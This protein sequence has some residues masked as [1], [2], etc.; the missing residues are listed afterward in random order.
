MRGLR[1]TRPVCHRG[2]VARQILHRGKSTGSP[3]TGSARHARRDVFVSYAREDVE[4]V[5]RLH[6]RLQE[7]GKT[8]YVDFSDIP[9]WSDD[10]QRELYA[11]I[12]ASDTF[13]LVIS[14]DSIP[15]PNVARELDRAVAQHKRLKPLLLRDVDADRVPPEVARP[16]WIDFRDA[17]GFD[18]RFADL[19]T[20]LGT[21]V[22]WVR[23]HTRFLLAANDWEGRGEDRSLLLGRSDLRD[24]DG[25]LARQ[26]GKDPAPS[27]LQIRFILASRRA[28]ARRQRLLLGSVVSALA[29]TAGLAIFAFVQRGQAIDQRDQARSRELAAL[30]VAQ[31]GS[32]PREGLRLALQ[33]A[34]AANT[35]QAEGALQ[36]AAAQPEVRAVLGTEAS[37]SSPITDSAVTPDGRYAVTVHQDRLGR[38]WDLRSGRL[39]ATLR[40]HTAPIT[41][42]DISSDG[43]LAVT[44][45]DRRSSKLSDGAA[46][47]WALPSGRL[48]RRLRSDANGII[49]AVFSPDGKSV[50]TIGDFDALDPVVIW[51]V[52]SGKRLHAFGEPGENHSAA[53]SPDG[54]RVATLGVTPGAQVAVWDARRGALVRKFRL[55]QNQF[56]NDLAFSPD[57]RRLAVAGDGVGFIAKLSNG[58]IQ[59]LPGRHDLFDALTAVR[60]CPDGTCVVTTSSDDTAR[61]WS[62]SG[63]QLTL[64]GH[65][66]DVTGSSSS[67]DGRLVLTESEDGT[68]R[69]WSRNS[70]AQLAVL[71]GHK[72]PVVGADF[73]GRSGE[74]LTTSGDGTGFVW[75]PGV[76]V[77]YPRGDLVADASFGQDGD[78][79]ATATLEG[80]AAIWSSAGKL[81]HRLRSGN[82]APYDRIAFSPDGTRLL[83]GQDTVS[84]W[85]STGKHLRSFD[86][87]L[88]YPIFSPD[89]KLLA[90]GGT[91]VVALF[92]ASDGRRIARLAVGSPQDRKTAVFLPSFSGDSRLVA[93]P[94]ALTG[95]HLWD[96]RRGGRSIDLRT[97]ERID[98]VAF[99][100]DGKQL[101]TSGD[102]VKVARVWDVGARTNVV[103][104]RYP[105][106]V[107][108]LAYS[109]D[110]NL[111]SAVSSGERAVRIYDAHT[112]QRIA[113][114]RD[115][116][117]TLDASF[118][119]DSRLLLTVSNSATAHLWDARSGR[120][121][122]TIAGQAK[123]IS[124]AR[125]SSDGRSIVTASDD[126]TAV[127]HRCEECLPY[128]D[129]VK[130]ARSEVARLDG[131]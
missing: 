80:T 91:D 94:G 57:G 27:D 35:A 89:S 112:L 5:R 103:L 9:Q 68:A 69:V 86:R 76:T 92:D 85:S 96:A 38:V 2:E 74:I 107:Q 88:G 114:L 128:A 12:D 24:A 105:S 44:A 120:L 59:R 56:A 60:F 106:G 45:S 101:V 83:T 82:L 26:A 13:V 75:D 49:T 130:L 119:P 81:L 62:V 115:E 66:A 84:L 71:R 110:G 67:N 131:D 79:V 29:V 31:L 19:L 117:E 123:P 53:W 98:K 8:S 47:V 63:R 61:L 77:L 118:D 3:T 4:F 87:D 90:I 32:D 42:V 104:D 16:Q 30:A 54:R 36:Q 34:E 109:P 97:Q 23:L 129:L 100:P 20:V 28:A 111:I 95:A 50:V 6:N 46:R 78:S 127:I 43:R 18:A 121:V 11:E 73:L 40:G 10:W 65:T 72:G 48:V 116:N 22:E 108:A 125:F 25:W 122:A 70:G 41:D 37:G 17:T 102:T 39:V 52:G 93:A 7:A 64:R 14:P 126:G 1:T 99:S 124:A 15:S 51:D 21:D 55:G 113:V 58:R 33:S